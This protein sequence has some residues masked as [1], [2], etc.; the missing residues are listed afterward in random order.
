MN[1]IYRLRKPINIIWKDPPSMD[2]VEGGRRHAHI[3]KNN[4]KGCSSSVFRSTVNN[5][6]KCDD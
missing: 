3:F 6:E 2:L 5:W 4:A 1:R